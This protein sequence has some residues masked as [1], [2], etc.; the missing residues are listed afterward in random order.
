MAAV[1]SAKHAWISAVERRRVKKKLAQV[2]RLL[3]DKKPIA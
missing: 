1:F 3:T 2:G